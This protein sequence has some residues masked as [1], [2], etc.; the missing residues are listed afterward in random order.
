MESATFKLLVPH[1]PLA[2]YYPFQIYYAEAVPVGV[3][4]KQGSHKEN[5]KHT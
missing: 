1:V 4:C 5:E 2:Y 3:E